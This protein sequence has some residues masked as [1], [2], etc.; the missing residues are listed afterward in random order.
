MSLAQCFPTSLSLP[1]ST[2]PAFVVS[3]SDTLPSVPPKAK[4][5][6]CVAFNCSRLL[7]YPSITVSADVPSSLPSNVQ[8]IY[9]DAYLANLSPEVL[10]QFHI[11]ARLPLIVTYHYSSNHRFFTIWDEEW[12]AITTGLC[13]LPYYCDHLEEL[14]LASERLK[15]QEVKRKA[16]IS[17]EAF[18]K[19]QF[20]WGK[21][22]H[23]GEP[24]HKQVVQVPSCK[25][26]EVV[27]DAVDDDIE[28]EAPEELDTMTLDYP[29]E[30]LPPFA[31][32]LTAP[33][34]VWRATDNW[35]YSKV[36]S[37]KTWFFEPLLKQ[38][39]SNGSS[40]TWDKMI[41]TAIEH[42][43]LRIALL[44][45]GP[46]KIMLEQDLW[47]L[48]D[49]LIQGAFSSLEEQLCHPSSQP[50]ASFSSKSLLQFIKSLSVINMTSAN[51]I[52]SQQDKLL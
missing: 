25:G 13:S 36:S 15:T 21:R 48:A 17:S 1:P 46:S 12:T 14:A 47:A 19:S 49:G 23:L 20:H 37:L 51:I 5:M 31:P 30:V 16:V 24:S 42:V 11:L 52:D 22:V 40:P 38:V 41:Q 45:S 33:S 39:P 2:Q 4:K 43:I 35:A 8:S 3:L 10:E 44:V 6:Q 32:V 26:K 7:Q 34:P 50:P 18:W 29:E 27:Q 28:M 9:E